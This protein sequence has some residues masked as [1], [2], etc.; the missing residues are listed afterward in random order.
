MT[1]RVGA[2]LAS[3]SA[4][5][6][7]NCQVQDIRP[8]ILGNV[9]RIEAPVKN[10]STQRGYG[11]IVSRE[12]DVLWVA[13][14]QHVVRWKQSS[15]DDSKD[16]SPDIVVLMLGHT[17]RFKLA[18]RPRWLEKDTD[19]AFLPIHA[20]LS[21]GR[22]VEPWRATVIAG[23]INRDEPLALLGSNHD[24][25]AIESNGGRIIDDATSSDGM[26]LTNIVG[27]AGMPAQ[28]GAPVAT[29]T[30][31]IGLYLASG[32]DGPDD[33]VVV[34]ISLVEKGAA[35]R[36][37]PWH[38]Q[39]NVGTSNYRTRVCI[40]HAGSE[41]PDIIVAATV[42]LPSKVDGQCGDV[43]AGRQSISSADSEV[44]CT[45]AVAQLAERSTQNISVEC[46]VAITGFWNNPDLGGAQLT[47]LAKGLWQ[48]EGLDQSPYGKISGRV[49]GQPPRLYF[50]GLTGAGRPISGS[51]VAQRDRLSFA[52]IVTTT[53]VDFTGVLKR[54]KAGKP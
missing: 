36:N 9:V 33:A 29:P 27:L 47:P 24:S 32:A 31:I 6:T 13:T 19:V 37:V 3:A 2:L 51:I 42:L 48:F 40:T 15:A 1:W 11:L 44:S 54:S 26:R 45:P 34:P 20:P 18:A 23:T 21:A 39:R 22:L 43:F 50:D 49:T 10:G 4:I 35:E 41:R 25:I 14:A 46:H 7:G 12:G 8:I 30:G 53:K 28:S 5:S 17:E 16:Y 52:F 38:L